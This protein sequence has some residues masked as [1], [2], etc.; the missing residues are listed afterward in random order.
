MKNVIILT[1]VVSCLIIGCK[2]EDEQPYGQAPIVSDIQFFLNKGNID[3]AEE[4]SI[5]EWREG[6]VVLG[7]VTLYDPDKDV[8]TVVF[9]YKCLDNNKT[10]SIT[11]YVNQDNDIY[12]FG[13]VIHDLTP[14][15]WVLTLT[16]EDKG[17]NSTTFV[18]ENT[19]IVNER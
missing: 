14:G 12:M 18:Y 19:L 7:V 11:V 5:T 1:L 6:D 2:I 17:H 9:N 13:F 4:Q 3:Y 15:Q 10:K 8:K 16:V